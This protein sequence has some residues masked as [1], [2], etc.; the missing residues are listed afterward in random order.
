[1]S[2]EGA[3]VVSTGENECGPL[4]DLREGS[5]LQ[6]AMFH[7]SSHSPIEAEESSVLRFDAFRL[8]SSS[9]VEKKHEPPEVV[10]EATYLVLCVQYQGT[11][12]WGV[13][14]DIRAATLISM[15]RTGPLRADGGLGPGFS[16]EVLSVR[17]VD[18]VQFNN[19]DPA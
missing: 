9:W 14:R 8:A 19:G 17:S 3:T 4:D 12:G 16:D 7:V 2:E 11:T 18:P 10:Y 5:L 6:C 1:M 13:V 15:R